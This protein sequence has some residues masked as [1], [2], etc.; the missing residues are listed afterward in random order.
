MYFLGNS[1]AR[2]LLTEGS[3]SLFYSGPQKLGK[4][5]KAVHIKSVKPKI[6]DLSI[7][8]ACVLSPEHTEEK[9]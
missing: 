9:L 6:Q 5:P 7:L 1:S 2:T 8:E 4:Q 3:D